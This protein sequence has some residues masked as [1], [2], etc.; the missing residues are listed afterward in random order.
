MA[1]LQIQILSGVAS[2]ALSLEELFIALQEQPLELPAIERG[3][4]AIELLCERHQVDS[5]LIVPTIVDCE[6]IDRSLTMQWFQELVLG[7][8]AYQENYN[9][10]GSFNSKSY[11]QM[12]DIPLLSPQ[13]AEQITLQVDVS[14]VGAAIMTNRPSSG[15]PGFSGSPEAELGLELVQLSRIP[16]TGYGDISWLAESILAEPGTLVK[17]NPTHGLAAI[18]GSLHLE[19][20]KSLQ[21]SLTDPVQWP[22]EISELLHGGTISV[23]E[24]TLGG[25]ASVINAGQI[26]NN[27]GIVVDIRALGVTKEKTKKTALESR[28]AKVFP[29]INAALFSLDHSGTFTRD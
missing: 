7:S 8:Q 17:P 10:P 27:A 24:D 16:L 2:P 4:A 21:L 9:K 19:K 3:L 13:N 22:R 1:F 6:D 18:L 28:G 5:R 14:R 25:L 15:P 11:L 26:L 29:D 20:T 23:F 12:Y